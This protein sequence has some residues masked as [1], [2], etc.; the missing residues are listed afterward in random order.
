MSFGTRRAYWSRNLLARMIVVGDE[1][2]D[3]SLELAGQIVLLKQDIRNNPLW[4]TPA[5]GGPR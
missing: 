1:G 5:E 3:P 4:P 2:L